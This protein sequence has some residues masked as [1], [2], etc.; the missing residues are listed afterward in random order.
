MIVVNT[1]DST[2]PLLISK[3]G[4]EMSNMCHTLEDVTQCLQAVKCTIIVHM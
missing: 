4:L 1:N 3:D 2:L